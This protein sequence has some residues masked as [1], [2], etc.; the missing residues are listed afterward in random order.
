MKNRVQVTLLLL[1]VLHWQ[2]SRRIIPLCAC[3]KD[4]SFP[5]SSNLNF[6]LN[7]NVRERNLKMTE[8]EREN[9]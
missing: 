2:T 8:R 3:E 4:G 5:V 1:L 7:A 6:T 9:R